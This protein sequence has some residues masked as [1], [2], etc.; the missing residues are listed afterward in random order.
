MF[1]DSFNP[2]LELI[3][4]Q[5]QVVASFF[6]TQENVAISALS[7]LPD[8]GEKKQL[9]LR[10]MEGNKQVML[11]FLALQ[12][13]TLV[14]PRQE[15]PLKPVATIPASPAKPREDPGDFRKTVLKLVAEQ[16]GF[17]PQEIRTEAQLEDEL[18]IDSIT[19]IELFQQIMDRF[20]ILND[21]SVKLPTVETLEDLFQIYDAA[22]EA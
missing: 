11:E 6:K 7:L 15:K 8:E 2:E 9:F 5:H 18:G 19:K 12:R 20:P 21:V 22:A 4:S 1:R 14:K 16:T 17:S 3:S 10:V 13:G